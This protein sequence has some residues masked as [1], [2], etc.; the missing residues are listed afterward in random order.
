MGTEEVL[1]ISL[2]GAGI[3]GYEA[4]ACSGPVCPGNALVVCAYFEV[5]DEMCQLEDDRLPPSPSFLLLTA[6][7]HVLFSSLLLYIN[8]QERR[9]LK[10]RQIMELQ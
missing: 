6:H 2:C 3:A 8:I 7:V 10:G 5:Y 1:D 9:R 4:R